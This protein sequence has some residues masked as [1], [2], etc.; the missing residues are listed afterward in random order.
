MKKVQILPFFTGLNNWLTGEP[1][2]QKK[3]IQLL[4]NGNIEGNWNE[5]GDLKKYFFYGMGKLRNVATLIIISFNSHTPEKSSNWCN[6]EKWFIKKLFAFC[7][8]ANKWICCV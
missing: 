5:A 4:E 8:L 6:F 7:H 1:V 3:D 2:V